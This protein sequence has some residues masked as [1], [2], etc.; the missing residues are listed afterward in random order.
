MPGMA[1]SIA[2]MAAIAG[3]AWLLTHTGEMRSAKAAQPAAASDVDVAQQTVNRHRRETG[4][5]G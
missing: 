4:R 2:A 3:G 5:T 1:A